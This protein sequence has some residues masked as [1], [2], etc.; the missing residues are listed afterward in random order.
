MV[1]Q[2]VSYLDERRLKIDIKLVNILYIP[3]Q[4]YFE[5]IIDSLI[6]T[7]GNEEKECTIRLIIFEIIKFD[8]NVK[9]GGYSMI[10]Q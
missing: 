3:D 1:Y 7:Q 9:D 10:R 2:R 5:N 8:S 4:S 6:E